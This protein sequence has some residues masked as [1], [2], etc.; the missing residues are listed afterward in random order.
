MDE[1]KRELVRSWLVK[2]QHDLAAARKLAADPEPYLDT[3]IYHCQQAAE[4]AAKAYLVYRDQRFDKI[5]D[6]RL[7]IDVAM[8]V[9][10]ALEKWLEVGELLTPYATAF[11]YPGERLEPDRDEFEKAYQEAEAFYRFILTLLPPEVRP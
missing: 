8:A 10:P 3:A 7:L 2:A 5:H 6:I 11:R 1:A 9:E 4:K